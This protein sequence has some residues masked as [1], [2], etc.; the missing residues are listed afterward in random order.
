[1]SQLRGPTLKRCFIALCA[2]ALLW[3][4]VGCD[5]GTEEPARPTT[6]PTGKSTE[7]YDDIAKVKRV[8]FP[9]VPQAPKPTAPLPKNASCVTAECHADYTRAPQIHSPVAQF[10][11]DA[12]HDADTGGHK[13][14]LK[15]D[16]SQ[17]C[18]FC[19]AVSGTQSHQHKALEQGC[20]SCHEPHTS[21]TKFLLKAD[22]VEQ[23]CSRCHNVPLKKFAHEP[24][25][26]GECTLCH[27]PHQSEN[28]K[29][30]RGGEGS[31]ECFT[32]HEGLKTV[33]ASAT[34]VH[35]PA[36]K[37]CNSCHDPHSTDNI[38]QLRAPIEQNCYN[39]HDKLKKQVETSNVSHAAM[40]T[41]EKCANCH[42]AH[43]SDQP[44]LL[45]HRMDEV[46]LTC[47]DKALKASDGHMIA[48]MK[49]VLTTSQFL[50]GPIRAGSCSGCHD[51]HGSKYPNLL[52]REFPD[53]FYTAFDVGK[54]ALCFSCHEPQL[55]LEPKTSTLTNFR[56]GDE[57]LHFVHVN[58]DDKGRSCK[59]CHALHGSNLPN[60]MASEVPFEGSNWSMPIEY[61][62][63][64]DGGSCSPGC[65]VPKTY[66]RDAV[67]P[68]TMPTT[69][70]VP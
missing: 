13:Y 59:T 58:R 41:Q 28:A 9:V 40:M 51:P 53:K 27:S 69:R 49:P 45:K 24:F 61:V 64:A 12:C 52:D 5:R 47:H 29:L 38:K 7:H 62:K 8:S 44:A 65:H 37:D 2:V 48:N 46:C 11:C 19:H 25:L 60:H 55:V 1:M 63:T 67:L 32:C 66:S 30:L 4:I 22:N 70:G 15:R 34:H 17:T 68:T 56:N 35:Q 43:A 10:A 21:K 26:K 54:Y 18:T 39:C 23:L 57:N 36:M 20:I 31:A 14:P 42:N 33:M 6:E 3:L 16:A 50:H